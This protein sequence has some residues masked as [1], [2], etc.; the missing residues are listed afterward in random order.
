MSKKLEQIRKKIDVLDDRIHDALMERAALIEDIAAEK[1]KKKVSYVQPAREAVMIRRLLKRHEGVLPPTT[2][3]RIWRELVGAVSLLQTGL[4]V[5]VSMEEEDALFWDMARNYF[6]SAVPMQR[7]SSSIGA[8][9]SVREDEASFAIVPWPQG[10]G[11]NPWWPH[12]LNQENES[13]K[14]VCALPYG[15]LEG[16]SYKALVVSKIKFSPSGK[17]HSFVVLNCNRNISR[18]RIVE[19]LKALKFSPLSIHSQTCSSNG[20]SSLHLVELDDYIS[21][22]DK[23][24]AKIS[25]QFEDCDVHCS[26]LGGYPVPPVFKDKKNV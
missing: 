20:D 4:K 26:V 6:G 14:I 2:I 23:R 12:L 3:V 13:I 21:Q 11:A 18:S 10:E 1:R 22:T 8:I 17:D 7:L 19:K 16:E 25:G 9:A 15:V 5:S 24:L